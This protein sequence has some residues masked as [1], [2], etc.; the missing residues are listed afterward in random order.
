MSIGDKGIHKDKIR[1][2]GDNV[3]EYKKG[4]ARRNISRTDT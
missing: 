1:D 2:K 4:S 3:D